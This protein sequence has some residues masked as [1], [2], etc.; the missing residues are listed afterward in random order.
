MALLDDRGRLFGRV[1]LLDALVGVFV[2]ALVPLAYASWA[3]FRT[4]APVIESVVPAE[5]AAGLADQS[6]EVHGRHLRPF[7]RAGVGGTAARFLFA[8]SES[9]QVL[10]PALPPGTY[11][12]LLLDSKELARLPN[13]VTVKPGKVVDIQVRFVTRPEVLEEVA[14][15]HRESSKTDTSRPV[16]VSYEVTQELLGTTKSDLHEGRISIVK[17]VVRLTA[18]WTANGWQADGVALKAGAPFTL[19]TPTYVLRG[20]ILDVAGTDAGK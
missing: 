13:A 18:N 10:L 4:P 7:L 15:H 2:F 14:R 12:L 9:A 11:D 19:T 1:N 8:S 3:L 17:G 20:E 16:L 5:V 6:I